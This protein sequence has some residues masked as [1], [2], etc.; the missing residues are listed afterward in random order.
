MLGTPTQF[1]LEILHNTVRKLWLWGL[2]YYTS[3][4]AA[5]N[6]T[7]TANV[8]QAV[9]LK[10]DRQEIIGEEQ[11][12][13]I[14]SLGEDETQ[15]TVWAGRARIIYNWEKKSIQMAWHTSEQELRKRQWQWSGSDKRNQAESM[16]REAMTNAQQVGISNE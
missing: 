8:L 1:A 11:P 9:R 5:L 13:L 4:V 2:H 10:A 12:I 7:G 6:F 15:T 3:P 16:S 14:D